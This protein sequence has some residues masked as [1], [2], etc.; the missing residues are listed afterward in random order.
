MKAAQK[1]ADL[2]CGAGGTSTGVLQAA[3]E[4]GQRVNLVAINHWEMAIAT[5]SENHPGV[6]HHNSDLQNIDPREVVPSGKLRL[7][8]ASPECTHF[9]RARGGKPMSKQSR[10]SV[11]YVLKWINNLDV[12]DILIENVPDFEGWGPLH[13]TCNC[14]QGTQAKKHL[15]KCRYMKPIKNRKG[16]YFHRFIRKLEDAGYTVSWRVLRA[17]DY[18]DPTTRERLFIIARKN[19][20][21][22]WP[23]PTHHKDGGDMFGVL[24]R[25]KTAREIIDWTIKGESIFNR[26]KP[27]VQNTL[28]RIMAGLMKYGGKAFVL[29][30]QSGAAPRDIDQPIPTIATAGK[31]SFIEPYLVEYHN[32]RNSER[33]TRSV[34]QPLPTLDTSNRFG[35]AEPF[36]MQMD[37]GGVL[38]SIDKPMA[39]IT[40]ADSWALVEPFILTTNW[41]G[42]NRSPARSIDEPV[43]TVMSRNSIGLVEPFLVEYYGTGESSSVDEPIKTLTGKDRF[44]LVEPITFEKDGKRYVLDI[45]FRMLQPHELAR[46]MSFPIDYRFHGSR[47]QIV[48]QIGNAV[49]VNLAKA[50]CKALLS[51]TKRRMK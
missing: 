48:K 50:L 28:Q 45:R 6:E 16:E 20:P 11:K 33:R 51:K 1:V 25:W 17:A 22:E 31:I 7:L 23:E 34:D 42:T 29:G 46:A 3:K 38:H 24:P 19:S 5:H 40:S 47:E 10:A 49:P 35:L 39:T 2:F 37:Q 21:I 15:K 32:G 18:G 14:G 8:V 30:Q 26:K 43:P 27:L 12:E 36:I 44:A 13:R 4:L 9:S 41:Q